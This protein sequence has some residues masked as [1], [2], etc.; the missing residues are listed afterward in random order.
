MKNTILKIHHSDDVMVA[1]T[2]L[3]RGEKLRHDGQSINLQDGI[4]A[5]HKF[6]ARD[7]KAGET[8]RMYG[9]DVG[10]AKIAIAK[11]SLISETNIKNLAR[12]YTSKGRRKS[13]DP[14]DIR[15]FSGLTFDGYHRPDGQVGTANYW[16]VVPLVFCENRNLTTIREAMAEGLGYGKTERYRRH[17]EKLI[18]LYQTG[19]S[20][21]ELLNWEQGESDE[22]G[23]SERLFSHVDGIKFLAHEG[24]CGGTPDDSE[25]LCGLLAGY[26]THPNVAG[27][28]VLSLG[29]QHAQ[30]E[31]LEGE[32]EKR[33]P[34][35]DRPLYIFEQ[36]RFS[37]ESV[38]LRSAISQTFVGLIE[39][40]KC[41]RG[42]ARLSKLVLGVECGASDGFSGIS[43]NPAIG[44]CSDLLVAMGGTVI[45]SEFPE[46][47]GVEQDLIDR[48][49]NDRVAERFIV[50]QRDYEKKARAVGASFDMNPSPGNIRDGL[51]TNTIKSAGAVRKG[52]ISPITDVLD[53]SEWVTESGL[54]LLCT[55]G[56]DVESTTGL[57][58]AGAN[59]V[60]FSTGVGAPTGNPVAPVIKVS[61]NSDLSTRMS[62]IIDMDAGGIIT[63]EETTQSMGEKLLKLCIETASGRLITKA[64][65]LDQDD[66]I[67][68]KRAVSL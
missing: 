34:D 63:S 52:G 25:A 8:I 23:D 56:N 13:W 58:G 27:A 49:V 59:L 42:P 47:S 65:H 55:P 37:S 67:P 3:R 68:W 66:F 9:V 29:C 31:I 20:A 45:L 18:Q 22:A 32:I 35:F 30:V 53:Y 51:V 48:C 43:A 12:D 21:E 36:Q 28:T 5:K 46:L 33:V 16:V 39:A 4:P 19:A 10:E 60:L 6:A 11:G 17:V 57:V 54:N 14:P 15:R 64:M 40:N 7:L 50:L 2:D 24:G 62:D 41:R 61:S 44:H 26:I 38:M 1:L